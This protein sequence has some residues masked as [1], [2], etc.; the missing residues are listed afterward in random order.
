[1]FPNINLNHYEHKVVRV[2]EICKIKN[3]NTYIN[4][5]GGTD[6]YS[7]DEFLM[8]DIDLKFIRA[9]E[10]T[11][12]QFGNKFAPYLSIIDVLMFNSK[13][14]IKDLLNNYDFI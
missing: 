14:E 12:P 9:R 3:A 13:D 4:P 11:Y 10:I 8:N 2:V 1:M 7:K 5:I 6:L